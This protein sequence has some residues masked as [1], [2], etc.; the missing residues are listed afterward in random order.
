MQDQPATP[1]PKKAK[2]DK[3]TII[4]DDD[5]LDDDLQTEL[6]SFMEGESSSASNA[7][8]ASASNGRHASGRLAL[9]VKQELHEGNDAEPTSAA[10]PP[11]TP[12]TRQTLKKKPPAGKKWI[13][14]PI[15]LQGPDA[16]QEGMWSDYDR[17]KNPIGMGCKVHVFVIRIS[18][19]Q[20]T[21]PEAG[22]LYHSK[23]E[24]GRTFKV[25]VNGASMLMVRVLEKDLIPSLLPASSVAI[26]KRHSVEMSYTV[27]FVSETD[28]LRITG[29]GSKN[30]KLGKP[31]TLPSEDG[32]GQ[33]SGW[34]LSV[35]GMD[36]ALL[37]GLRTIKISSAMDYSQVDE[38]LKPEWQVRAG[39]AA[40]VFKFAMT[41]NL[42][43]R[44]SE[45]TTAGRPFLKQLSVL[46]E[47]GAAI[48]EEWLLGRLVALVLLL[49]HMP[50]HAVFRMCVDSV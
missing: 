21:L 29:V 28:V 18:Y 25:E 37:N 32:S 6:Q 7:R 45:E 8:P 47:K 23:S 38:L 9:A 3:K 19:P 41:K 30:L 14:C 44:P 13:V 26:Q 36:P 2:L 27:A 50:C 15:C 12:K 11:K 17:Q 34:Y 49:C 46:M 42:E 5:D 43:Q 48:I 35:I 10:T 1:P 33:V 20:M 4:A 16:F 22:V 39:Q 31:T 40:D 24:Q